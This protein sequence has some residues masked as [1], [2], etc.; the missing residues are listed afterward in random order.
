M[1]EIAQREKS[2]LIGLTAAALLF[3][4]F[5]IFVYLPKLQSIN[6]IRGQAYSIEQQIDMT[7]TMLGDLSKLG[8]LLADMQKELLSFEERLPGRKNISSVISELSRLA[9][10]SSVKMVSIKQEEPIPLEDENGKSVKMGKSQ[11][12][13]MNIE[14]NLKGTYKAI[15]EYIKKTQ[16]SLNILATIDEISIKKNKAVEKELF[17]RLL[18]TVYIVNKG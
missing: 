9:K 8:P 18:L 13:A 5:F 6:K 4:L 11:L 14:L 2:F 1:K 7:Q 15:A 12:E 17:S 10:T 3:V 16:D